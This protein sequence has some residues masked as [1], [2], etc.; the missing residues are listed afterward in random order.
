MQTTDRRLSKREQPLSQQWGAGYAV[1]AD[2]LQRRLYEI[3]NLVRRIRWANA[4]EDYSDLL[5]RDGV[6][7]PFLDALLESYGFHWADFIVEY[8]DRAE[9]LLSSPEEDWLMMMCCC[10]RLLVPMSCERYCVIEDHI[11]YRPIF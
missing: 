3:R 10:D 4:H 7:N 1:Y 11:G 2:A 6:W 5:D 9:R 8:Y